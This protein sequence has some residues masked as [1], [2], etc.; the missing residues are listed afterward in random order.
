VNFTSKP[1]AAAGFISKE[2]R[3]ALELAWSRANAAR[4][5]KVKYT[6]RPVLSPVGSD[7]TGVSEDVQAS[8]IGHLYQTSNRPRSATL[9]YKRPPDP[10][11]AEKA[12]REALRLE[13]SFVPAYYHLGRALLLQKHYAEA[14]DPSSARKK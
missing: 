10:V 8:R 13:P 14:I 5:D 1:P 9:R 6:H 3:E 2:G 4:T 11:A 12:S 7:V